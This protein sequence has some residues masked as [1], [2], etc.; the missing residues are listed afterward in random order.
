QYYLT[1]NSDQGAPSG[2]GWYDAGSYAP[3]SVST[4]S[5]P[6]YGVN[7]VFNGWQGS[8]VQSSSQSTQVM[9]DGAKTVTATWRTD[10]TLLYA[11][12]AVVLV[13][14]LLIAAAGFY[15][16]ARRRRET[17]TQPATAPQPL[18]N[19]KQTT[20]RHRTPT[21]PDVSTTQSPD[22]PN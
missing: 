13:A 5:S 4:P 22:N 18:N 2:A 7:M 20:R 15:S 10:A 16:T 9:M 3:I 14:I 11:T 8:G 17:P 21:P 12:I 1:I 6:S 19:P